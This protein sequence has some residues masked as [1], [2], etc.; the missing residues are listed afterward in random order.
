MEHA[1]AKSAQEQSHVGPYMGGIKALIIIIITPS[2]PS[3]ATKQ[4]PVPHCHA[5]MHV[6]GTHQVLIDHVIQLSSHLHTGRAA[7]HNHKGQQALAL[8]LR[9]GGQSSALKALRQTPASKA[10]IDQLP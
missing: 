8:L 4:M 1:A 10:N 6:P 9:G 3:L 2:C 5:A 7:T